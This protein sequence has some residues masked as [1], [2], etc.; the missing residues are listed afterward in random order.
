MTPSR[1]LIATAVLVAALA[2]PPVRGGTSN[3]AGGK[4]ASAIVW[5]HRL[6]GS[7]GGRMGGSRVDALI[8]G[9]GRTQPGFAVTL[10][11]F[12]SLT[13]DLAYTPLAVDTTFRS[14]R[15][16]TF[17]GASFGVVQDGRLDYRLPIYE[18]TLRSI[19]LESRWLRLCLAGNLKVARADIQLTT[20]GQSRRLALTLP[21]PMVGIG[22][23]L[24]ASRSIKL[25]GSF[26]LLDLGLGAASTKVHDWDVGLIGDFLQAIAGHTLRLAGGY[27]RLS[28]ALAVEQDQ[29]DE[30]SL[31]IRHEGPFAE[32]S[33]SF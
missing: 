31:D 12:G 17:G 21:I 11:T 22:A 16:F 4:Q 10:K 18:A 32:I 30:A 19:V 8:A 7:L 14:S 28:V 5:F 33:I 1:P 26:K 20:A 25:Y 15:A 2:G 24:N 23:Q 3:I 6:T 9:A 29:D 27:R 13:L